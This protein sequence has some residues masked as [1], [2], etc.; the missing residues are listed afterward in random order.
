MHP[1]EQDEIDVRVAANIKWRR[2]HMG[3]SQRALAEELGVSLEEVQRHESGARIAPDTLRRIA[4]ALG[5]PMVSLFAGP[6][7]QSIC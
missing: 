3:L 1:P 2:I 6:T 7:P 5:A 4:Q